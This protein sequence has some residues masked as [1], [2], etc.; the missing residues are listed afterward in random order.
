MCRWSGISTSLLTGGGELGNI[1]P[2]SARSSSTKNFWGGLRCGMKRE[3]KLKC[4]SIDDGTY[5]LFGILYWSILSPFIHV[6]DPSEEL[7][8][9]ITE[10]QTMAAAIDLIGNAV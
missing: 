8:G 6:N 2:S 7:V 4:V 3:E 9:M 5:H 10:P 1:T